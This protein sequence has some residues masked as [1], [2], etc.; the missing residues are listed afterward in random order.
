MVL[1]SPKEIFPLY[2]QSAELIQTFRK[3]MN[4][5]HVFLLHSD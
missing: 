1:K 5:F 4:D 2:L 3:P